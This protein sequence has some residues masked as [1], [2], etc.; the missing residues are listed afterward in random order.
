MKIRKVSFNINNNNKKIKNK[1]YFYIRLEEKNNE[2]V[3]FYPT[4]L[5]REISREK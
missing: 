4:F 1:T 3:G 2:T 5:A